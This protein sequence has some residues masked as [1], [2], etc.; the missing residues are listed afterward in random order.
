MTDERQN[1]ASAIA[2]LLQ[3]KLNER[4]LGI[5]ELFV[6]P[7]FDGLAVQWTTT[8]G[9]FAQAEIQ[10]P[11]WYVEFRRDPEALVTMLAEAMP[12]RLSEVHWDEK[13]H[14]DLQ[15]L[16]IRVAQDLHRIAKSQDDYDGLRVASLLRLL[17]IDDSP[18]IHRV[19]RIHR[20]PLQFRVGH[21]LIDD[22]VDPATLPPSTEPRLVKV[23]D[24]RLFHAV[25]DGFDPTM[26]RG[27]TQE[28]SW[29][30]FLQAL[31]VKVEEHF[32]SV[33]ELVAHLAY[34]EGVVHAGGPKAKRPADEALQRSRRLLA[35]RGPSPLFETARAI[36]RVVL[37]AIVPLLFEC[38]LALQEGRRLFEGDGG[39]ETTEESA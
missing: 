22:V 19:N 16:F 20:L 4:G 28:L 38:S 33:R 26:W 2:T 12:R 31:V 11:T 7:Q 8:D 27:R 37:S 32:V 30:E 15:Y 29:D 3:A 34:V 35:F 36:G 1:V 13:G 23:H 5:E 24:G 9:T 10:R 18:L 14:L 25:G 39:V 21:V 17:L 6:S